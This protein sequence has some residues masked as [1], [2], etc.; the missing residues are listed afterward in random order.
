[1]YLQEQLESFYRNKTRQTHDN[2]LRMFTYKN[3]KYTEA[4]VIRAIQWSSIRII[5]NLIHYDG[6]YN[7]VISHEILKFVYKS[8]DPNNRYS[9]FTK[10]VIAK[11]PNYNKMNL[12]YI[13]D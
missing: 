6:V 5:T 12:R 8:L 7:R 4:D 10:K 13:L 1:M 2:V 9:K 11:H 3:L